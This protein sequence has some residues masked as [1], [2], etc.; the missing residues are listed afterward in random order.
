MVEDEPAIQ[1]LEPGSVKASIKT[2]GDLS[3]YHAHQREKEDL[4]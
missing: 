1:E 4:R 2:K 3:Y